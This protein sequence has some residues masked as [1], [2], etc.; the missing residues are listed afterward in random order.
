MESVMMKMT[1]RPRKEAQVNQLR[2]V[3]GT[4]DET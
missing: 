1:A 3:F 2:N 4:K